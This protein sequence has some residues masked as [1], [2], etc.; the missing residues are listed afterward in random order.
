MKK[1]HD[2]TSQKMIAFRKEQGIGLDIMARRC[3]VSIGLLSRLEN[4]DW[5]T[6]PSIAARI[7]AEYRLDLSDYNALVH[8]DHKAKTLPK[9]KPMRT[10]YIMDDLDEGR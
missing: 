2:A 9:P 8:S 5:I 6:H 3:G 1:G 4:D 7:C 10:T